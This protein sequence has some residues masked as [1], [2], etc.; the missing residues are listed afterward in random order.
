MTRL[1]TLEGLEPAKV[2]LPSYAPQEHG[3]G[4]VHLGAG[5]FMRS[6]IGVYTDE[7]LAAGGGDWRIMGV[8]LR[9]RAVAEQLN[10]Q[11]GL[12]TLV[13]RAADAPK[14]RIVGSVAGVVFAPE[15]HEHLMTLLTAQSTRIVSLTITEKGYGLDR[16]TGRLD[17][18]DPAIAAD[19]NGTLAR[20][21]SAVG[22]I[23][24]ALQQRRDA[25]TGPF[26]VL[27]CDN[28]PHNG[29]V[30]RTLVLDMAERID[31]DLAAWIAQTVTFPSTM[32]DRITPV[33][34]EETFTDVARILGVE[35]RA[36][37]EAEPFVQWVIEDAF[38]AGR[39]NWE[40]GG[41][42]FVEDVAPFE[43]MKLRMLNGA[44]SLLAYTGFLLG[45]RYVRDVMDDPDLAALVRRHVHAAADT[46]PPVPGID[47]ALYAN[48]LFGR[49]SNRAMAD[50]TYRIAMDGTQKLPPRIFEAALTARERKQ[51]LAPFAFATAAWMAY[52]RGVK[53]DGETYALRDPREAEIAAALAGADGS[54]EGIA[55]ALLGLPGLVPQ[56]LKS[57]SDWNDLVL[58]ALGRFLEEGPRAAVKAELI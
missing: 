23:T 29:E 25:G 19:L 14:P 2:T 11:N 10:P 48:D 9:S 52:A 30:I 58:L 12:Y 49:F 54:A 20:P 8:S 22:I 42:L 35:D 45:H 36:A 31:P 1:S 24:A 53:P 28:L 18:S 56:E 16:K 34:R 57:D 55:A 17:L 37:T 44:H 21:A 32:V 7:A 38:C 33:T 5:A 39:P 50:E 51:S 43:L 41:A 4:I 15:Q 26:T 40:A 3:I 6:H 47:L 46:L 13:E 27:S